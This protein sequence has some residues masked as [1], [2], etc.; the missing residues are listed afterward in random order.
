LAELQGTAAKAG[1]LRQL[2][3]FSATALVISNMVGTGIFATT[4]FMAG[5]LG[6]ARL[7]LACWGV[8]ALFALAGALSYS[9]LGV[10]F[11][12]SGGE[13]VYLTHAFGPA[14][15]FMT[16]WVSFF[17]GFSA[18]IAAAA[19][20]FSDYLG[21]F[22]PALKQANASIVVGSGALSLRLG[23]GQLAASALILLFT[24][25]NCLGVGRMA[26]IQNALTS[27]KL[28]VVV[29]FVVA[30]FT[31]GT[32]RWSHFSDPAIRTSDVSLP[33]QFVVS[34]LWVMVA[35]SGWNAATYVAE[36]VR[37][38]ERTLPVA[39]AAGT[40]VVAALYLGLN[41]VFIYSTPLESMKGVI[42]VGSL[43]AANLFGPRVGG[44]FSAL[45]A[46]SIMSTVSAMVTIGPRV[47][48]AMAKNRAFF[49]AAAEVHPRWHTPVYAIVGQGLCAM[50]MTV[51]PFP[52]LVVYIGMSLTLFTVLSV[53]ALLVFRR[54][55]SEWQ[56]LRVVDFCYPLIPVA[57]ILL[58]LA[59][60][61]Y[62]VIW[63]PK[64]SL[65]ALGT[66]VAG[67]LVF[68]F[69]LGR[70]RAYLANSTGESE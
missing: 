16:G 6:S 60:M 29:G 56:R 40:A 49:P 37:R 36:E 14:W 38:P 48:H 28:L 15:G 59:M 7:I 53:G 50:L 58:G 34:L 1:L 42:A 11:P 54:K 33:M 68:Q 2:G 21:Y 19:L 8:G 65:C 63:Q 43:S 23:G 61:I 10:N 18:P 69:R 3:L 41:L 30:G 45:M 20:A 46:L 26:K 32:G 17:A 47:Y 12:S 66:I 44:V 39:L 31:A 25:V 70:R 57:Y 67:A 4:G 5:D 55:R 51:T 9:E 64:A 24:V 27:A 22:F 13:Y 35:Y 52:E 62:G